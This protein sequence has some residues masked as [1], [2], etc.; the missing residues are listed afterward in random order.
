MK[1]K[2]GNHGK[3]VIRVS[4]GKKFVISE[5]LVGGDIAGHPVVNGKVMYNSSVY[6][7]EWKYDCSGESVKI[8]KREP[9]KDPSG[10]RYQHG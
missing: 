1:L 3:P 4:D 5:V 8:Y 10:D 2:K 7:D 6:L 9:V